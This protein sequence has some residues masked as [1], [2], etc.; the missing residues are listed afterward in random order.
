MSCNLGSAFW[1]TADCTSF[2]EFETAKEES[3]M[4]DDSV[5][6]ESESL[7]ELM[8]MYLSIHFAISVG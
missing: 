8:T 7:W 2:L 5:V 3:S 1:G 6:D 4:L